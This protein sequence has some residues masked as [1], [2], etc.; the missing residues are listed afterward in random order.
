MENVLFTST[1]MTPKT[2]EKQEPVSWT[3][4]DQHNYPIDLGDVV[5]A[6][7]WRQ[8][9]YNSYLSCLVAQKVMEIPVL[10][11]SELV[12]LSFTDPIATGTALAQS[13]Q[14]L[15]FLIHWKD[16]WRQDRWNDA[17]MQCLDLYSKG[18]TD[19]EGGPDAL[20]SLLKREE[21]CERILQVMHDGD[22]ESGGGNQVVLQ[23]LKLAAGG[24]TDLALSILRRMLEQGELSDLDEMSA[25]RTLAKVHLAAGN[26][27][28]AAEATHRLLQFPHATGQ[29]HFL[30]AACCLNAQNYERASKHL[31]RARALGVPFSQLKGIAG[32]VA[33]STGDPD[34]LARLE[35]G[36][37]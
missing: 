34:L 8:T 37:V 26:D 4:T 12:F 13:I 16:C 17:I 6:I 31:E 35:N 33:G 18:I 3:L 22:S 24:A 20:L 11:G 14:R 19:C 32:R 5:S 36:D 10:Y 21:Q 23:A 25:L 29:D 27:G 30:D 15:R 28:E 7:G 1:G 2:W 9:P